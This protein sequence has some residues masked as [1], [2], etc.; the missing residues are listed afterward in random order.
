M[1]KQNKDSHEDF[2]MLLPWLVNDSLSGKE[3]ERVLEHLLVCDACRETRDEIQAVTTF[4]AE[5]DEVNEDYLPA[6]RAL[7][8]RIEAAERDKRVLADFEF[9][10]SDWFTQLVQRMSWLFTRMRYVSATLVLM[11]AVV[12]LS[13]ELVPDKRGVLPAGLAVGSEADSAYKTLT[14]SMPPSAGSFHR[15]L[16]TFEP[17][18]ESEVIRDMLIKTSARIVRNS[19]LENSFVI[20]LEIP[21]SV[22]KVDFFD[23]ISEMDS[24]ISVVGV[25][26]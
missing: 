12:L 8:K 19:E 17:G 23:Q 21:S 3:R 22:N 11:V 6:F 24:V 20:D 16:I 7:Q 10:A 4:L 1:L 2:E 18:I 15:A 5:D 9:Q 25:A 13:P 26:N 14:S